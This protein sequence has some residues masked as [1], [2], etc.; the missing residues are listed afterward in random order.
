MP[1]TTTTS[2][3]TALVVAEAYRRQVD[4]DEAFRMR[5]AVAAASRI[6]KPFSRT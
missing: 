6:E 1:R 4:R 3:S 5:A 2:T